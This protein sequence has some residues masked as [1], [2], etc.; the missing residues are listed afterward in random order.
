MF[1]F[2]YVSKILSRFYSVFTFYENTFFFS[3]FILEFLNFSLEL[4]PKMVNG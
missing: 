4:Q 3:H 1:M 2:M